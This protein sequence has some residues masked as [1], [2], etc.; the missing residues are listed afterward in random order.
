MEKNIQKSQKLKEKL[1]ELFRKGFFHVFIGNTL[2]KMI[3]FISS[4]VVV[5]LVNK[6]D[7][8]YLAYA[9]NLYNYVI[10]YAGMGMSSAILKYC[11]TAKKKSTDKAYFLFAMK[12]GT[13]FQSI[14]VLFVMAYVTFFEIP[15]PEA[16]GMVYVLCLYPIFMNVLNT[17]MNYCRAHANNKLFANMSVVQTTIIFIGSVMFVVIIGVKGIAIARYL[18]IGT[19]I[20]LAY[21][22]LKKQLQGERAQKLSF[23]EKKEFIVMSL[24][25]MISSLFSL[26]M[27]MN[28]MTLINELLRDEII[29][30]NYKVAILIP[31]QLSFVTQSIIIYYFT[32]IAKMEDKEEIWKLSKKVGLVSSALIGGIT[33]LGIILGPFVIR[34]AY[35]NRYEDA[36]ILSNVFWIVNAINASVRMIP[37]NFLPAIG[38]AKFNA[39][40]AGIS[41]AVHVLLTYM[42][43]QVWG[44]WGAG[45][46]TGIVYLG[47]AVVYWGYLR[48]KCLEN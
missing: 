31:G 48:K 39:I 9:D 43:I 7:Y 38:I 32:I 4:I 19:A 20:L 45:V 36:I 21:K 11:A 10:A 30:A 23:Q 15:F 17:I 22:F 34:M 27:P 25:L 47:S 1:K 13:L 3:A 24:S 6:Q 40:V 8:A 44:I 42:A 16:K 33:V 18:A 46:A 41:C 2:V 37:M 26:I 12:Y 35:G 28:E 5:R 29:T 14:L